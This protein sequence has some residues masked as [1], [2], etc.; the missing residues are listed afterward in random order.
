VPV[1]RYRCANAQCHWQGLRV[2]TGHGSSR[3][4]ARGSS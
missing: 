2:G 4:S 1:R 3:A